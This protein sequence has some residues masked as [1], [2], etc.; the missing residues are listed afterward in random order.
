MIM[1]CPYNLKATRYPQ[2]CFECKVCPFMIYPTIILVKLSTWLGLLMME[3]S[4]FS[5]LFLDSL[6]RSFL[7]YRLYALL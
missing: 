5:V 1:N 7:M 6:N 2:F 4:I 3:D